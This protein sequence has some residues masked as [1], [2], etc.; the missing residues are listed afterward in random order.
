M[1]P[2]VVAAALLFWIGVFTVYFTSQGISP[3]D[4]LLGA[5]EPFNPE[6]ARWR[7]TGADPQSGL[8]REERLLVPEGGPASRYLERQVRHRDPITQ[9]I[10]VVEPPSRVR[11]QRLRSVRP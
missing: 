6:L 7:V 5:Y 2:V 9:R 8:I 4:F 1:I 10:V 11:R 3:L